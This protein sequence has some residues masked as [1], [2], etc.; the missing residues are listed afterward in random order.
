MVSWL[1][2]M[3]LNKFR[4]RQLKYILPLLIPR[5]FALLRFFVVSLFN[6]ANMPA[7]QSNRKGNDRSRTL[8]II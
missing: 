5:F 7:L 2:T 8:R 1:Y 3:L 6:I 4:L